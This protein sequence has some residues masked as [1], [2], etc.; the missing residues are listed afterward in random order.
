MRTDKLRVPGPPNDTLLIYAP[1]HLY[2][3]MNDLRIE[4]QARNGLRLWSEYFEKVIAL[5]PHEEGPAPESWE[6]L[7]TSGAEL[8]RVEIVAIPSA[9]RPD[10]FL[11][12]YRA[13]RA[14]W[15]EHIPRARYL[16][17]A[18]GGL[19]G[20][21]G[22]VGAI[23]A[24]AQNRSFAIWT[25]R[26]ES[27]VV[28]R[29]ARSNALLRRRIRDSLIWKP[30]E[31]LERSMIR[32]ADLGLFHGR[33]TFDAY[34]PYCGGHSEV[35]H[36]IHISGA[37]HIGTQHM[38]V[39]LRSIES[40]PLQIVY[41][42]RADPMKGPQDWLT[43]LE[44]L[45]R[46]GIDFQAVWLGEGS[47]RK[48]MIRQVIKAGLSAK[49]SLPGHVKDHEDI[50]SSLRRS[51]VFLFCH[52]TPESPRNL[53]ESLVSAT[54]I[55]GYKSAY[56]ADLISDHGG[57]VLTPRSD[58]S[59]LADELAKLANNRVRL[60]DLAHRARADGASFED[61]RVFEHRSDVIKHY[62]S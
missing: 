40:D 9:F 26:V 10:R 38:S 35:V 42:G 50:L 45:D 7:S 28:R 51:H 23:E 6:L 24:H 15:R 33:E 31:L 27:Q 21:W 48:A 47:E 12:M 16:S 30:M 8:D 13:T 59:A 60:A 57:G 4:R 52:K 20:D 56:P 1:V 43:C 14:V 36:D 32:R 55:V 39:K 25:D 44:T 3:S 17:F 11:R 54:P 22:A 62:L 37:D 46:I 5:M 58:T 61:Q 18:I 29:T 19:F 49:I 2:G 41:V 53:I 34:A